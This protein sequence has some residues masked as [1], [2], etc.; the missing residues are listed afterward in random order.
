MLK[1][2][3]D[4]PDFEL[5]RGAS[6]SASDARSLYDLL[7]SGPVIVY[8][9]PMDFTPV[10]TREAC[11][12]RDSHA[13]LVAQGFRVIG[14]NAMGES[15]H[16]RFRARH[17]L[18]FPL[19]ADTEK[20]VIRAYGA[21]GP[22]GLSTRRVS[23]LVGKDRKIADVAHADWRLGPHKSFVERALALRNASEPH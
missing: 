12:F 10:C 15:L 4:A 23:Y 16:E 8:F 13:D 18:P 3:D 11:F 9:Y 21:V 7:A 5:P 22:L 14:I 17:D 6:E 19:L 20:K 2:G 1:I